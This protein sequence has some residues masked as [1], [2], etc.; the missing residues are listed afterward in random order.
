ME[1]FN[2]NK[3]IVDPKATVQLL[4]II[5]ARR[6]VPKK[7]S[8]ISWLVVE[9]QTG[10]YVLIKDLHCF[11]MKHPKAVQSSIFNNLITVNQKT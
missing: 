6:F 3:N 1:N 7:R 8:T 2:Y 11:R 9:Q 10:H 4:S 5:E